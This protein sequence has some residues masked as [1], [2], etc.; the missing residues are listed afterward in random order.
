MLHLLETL[1][2]VERTLSDEDGLAM[3][4]GVEASLAETVPLVQSVVHSALYLVSRLLT[5]LVEVIDPLLL[6]D[7]VDLEVEGAVGLF[8]T[9]HL[10][11]SQF[12]DQEWFTDDRLL[13]LVFQFESVVV[14]VSH[15]VEEL[16]TGGVDTFEEGAV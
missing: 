4:L 16:L 2:Q 6:G 3:L 5:L 10:L 13:L 15:V 1:L 9:L 7:L 12:L 11:A 14:V 8:H